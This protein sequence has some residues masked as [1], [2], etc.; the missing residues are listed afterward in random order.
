MEFTLL[1]EILK[2]QTRESL[3]KNFGTHG[4]LM[5]SF[6]KLFI[7]H[8]NLDGE[9]MKKAS[10]QTLSCLNLVQSAQFTSTSQELPLKSSPG[11]R[12][13]ALNSGI[14]SPIINPFPFLTILQPKKKETLFTDQP[15]C[16]LIIQLMML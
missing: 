2:E 12:L 13:M 10:H 9:L 8:Q 15:V 1:K 5:D 4:Q 14:W 7:K 11:A 16:M 6:H 3:Q